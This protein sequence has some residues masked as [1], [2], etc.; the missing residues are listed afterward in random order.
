V[1]IAKLV[2]RA[3]SDLEALK[4]DLA[5]LE[6]QQERHHNVLLQGCAAMSLPKFRPTPL[7]H[8][9]CLRKNTKTAWPPT[10]PDRWFG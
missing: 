2:E 10:R 4:M 6:I 9:K 1:A 3:I 7:R 5:Q 8:S